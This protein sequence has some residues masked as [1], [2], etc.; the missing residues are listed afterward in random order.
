MDFD[1]ARDFIT[2]NASNIEDQILLQCYG[3]YKAATVGPC[4]TAKPP[5]YEFQN[6]AKWEAW[7][8]LRQISS[9]EA[10]K[11]Y[12][13]IVKEYSS[14]PGFSR[15]RD[16]SA[17]IGISVSTMANTDLE[18]ES[19]TVFDWAREGNL[20]ELKQSELQPSQVDVN[21]M[22][23]LHWAAD[24]GHVE[25]IEYLTDLGFDPNA[26][27]LEGSTPLHHAAFSGKKVSYDAL[28][29]G[30]ARHDIENLD[31]ETPRS[32]IVDF[33]DLGAASSGISYPN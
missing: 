31:G 26:Q 7:S 9:D 3:L 14:K 15:A 33:Q 16:P 20:A 1:E 10:K 24:R 28:V 19:K 30:G 21:K 2:Q 12:I 5:F 32:L 18:S 25:I 13:E 4:N 17:S 23:I 22:T 29:K 27:D 11:I 8:S 6:R